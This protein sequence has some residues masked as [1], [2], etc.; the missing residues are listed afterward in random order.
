MCGCILQDAELV[1]KSPP[2]RQLS[3]EKRAEYES[4]IRERFYDDY[5]GQRR[6]EYNLVTVY[7][8]H[9]RRCPHLLASN[10]GFPFQTLSHSFKAVRQN[11]ERKA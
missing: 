4:D 5:I 9:N 11:P 2:T 3:R 10:P 7:L 1:W 6:S 8:L